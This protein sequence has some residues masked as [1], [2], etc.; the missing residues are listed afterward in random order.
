MTPSFP[1]NGVSG[2]AGAV[3]SLGEKP[4]WDNRPG[5]KEAAVYAQSEFKRVLHV[6]EWP[7]MLDWAIDQHVR[8]RL[9]VDAVGGLASFA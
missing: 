6:D 2:H 1:T 5:V 9:A 7:A 3:Q 8:F 4:M